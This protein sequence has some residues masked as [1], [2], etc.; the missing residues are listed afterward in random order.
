MVIEIKLD[1]IQVENK[2]NKNME[3]GLKEK[4]GLK[5]SKIISSGLIK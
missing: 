2:E 4:N 3:N 5:V 1:N